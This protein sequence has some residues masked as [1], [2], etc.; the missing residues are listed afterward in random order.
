M[1]R[2]DYNELL[3]EH[4]VIPFP[5]REYVYYAYKNGSVKEFDNRHDAMTFSKLFE[6]KI[7]NEEDYQ[8]LLKEYKL[9]DAFIHDK[10]MEQVKNYFSKWDEDEIELMYNYA[11]R[12]E[13]YGY[14][15][16]FDFMEDFS[17]TMDTIKRLYKQ[18]YTS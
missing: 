3:K 2:P 18:K 10:W 1:E 12:Q 17:R 6:K 7:K 11:C 16:V 8:R 9:Q 13:S 15:A 14:N 5:E 4:K